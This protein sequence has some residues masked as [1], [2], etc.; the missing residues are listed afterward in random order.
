MNKM[1]HYITW[2]QNNYK[3]LHQAMLHCNHNI[4]NKNLNP[5][6]LESDCWSHTMM[7]C[8]VAEIQNYDKVVQ[9]AALLH[10]I[11][12]PISRTI[13]PKN[14]H[15]RFFDH[16]KISAELSV[17]I[18]NKMLLEQ[19]ITTNE[20]KNILILI[21]SHG[22]LYKNSDAKNIYEKFKSDKKLFILLTQLHY[23]D[24]VGRFS[25]DPHE[26][27]EKNVDDVLNYFENA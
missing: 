18:L 15:V 5:Y 19:M 22:E 20:L 26:T 8:K 9:I 10:D 23:C 17:D 13:N 27:N 14:N 16:E 3:E 21:A 12:K 11:G 6:H 4:D 7:V 25:A 2:F 1:Y 24:K